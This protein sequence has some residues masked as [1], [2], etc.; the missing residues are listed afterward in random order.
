MLLRWFGIHPV[1]EPEP[2]DSN[3]ASDTDAVD[4][5]VVDQPER[6]PTLKVL[7]PKLKP[8]TD[9]DRKWAKKSMDQMTQAM[10]SEEFMAHRPPELL[11]ADLKIAAVLF[12]RRAQGTLD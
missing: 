4:E 6:L 7:P 5:D 2:E 1:D 11:A 3:R 12:A 8:P 10:T 9:V